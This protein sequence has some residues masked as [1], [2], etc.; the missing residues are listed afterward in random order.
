MSSE[1][2]VEKSHGK[3]VVEEVDLWRLKVPS[4]DF[5]HV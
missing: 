3:F 5:I 4:E 2:S 1:F